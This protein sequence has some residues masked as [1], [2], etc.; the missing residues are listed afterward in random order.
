MQN[1]LN[2]PEP[3]DNFQCESCGK[4]IAKGDKYT[5]TLDGCYLCEEDAPSFQDCVDYW[6]DHPPEDRDEKIS[7]HDCQDALDAHVAAGGSPDDKPL[8]VM[9]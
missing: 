1:P 3:D 2:D 4:V 5:V 7:A 6:R 9:E 8:T